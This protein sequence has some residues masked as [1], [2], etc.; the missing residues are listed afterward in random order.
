MR[1]NFVGDVFGDALIP[2]LTAVFT[3]YLIVCSGPKAAGS[4]ALFQG[5]LMDLLSGGIRGLF[6]GFHLMVFCVAILGRGLFDIH[7]P[8][9]QFIITTLA[10][11]SGKL[12]FFVTVG[13]MSPSALFTWLWAGR[14]ASAALFSGILSPPLISALQGVRRRY[15]PDWTEGFDVELDEVGVLPRLWRRRKKEH[16][17]EVEA[18]IRSEKL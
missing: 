10:V 3:V 11:A 5:L 17:S 9:G 2:D 16:E 15:V 13:I 6:I 7:R 4:F 14:A 12:L 1:G 18:A 8:K